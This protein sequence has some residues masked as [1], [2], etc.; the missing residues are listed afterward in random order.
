M[1]FRQLIEICIEQAQEQALAGPRNNCD[2]LFKSRNTDLYYSH[3]HMECYYLYQ[4][5]K[6]Y[7]KVTRLLGHKCVSFAVGFLKHYILNQ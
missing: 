5:C 6:D 2:R 3:M 1:L 7:F 4:Q